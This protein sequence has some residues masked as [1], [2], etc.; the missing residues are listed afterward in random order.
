MTTSLWFWQ[1]DVEL[2]AFEGYDGEPV[3][4][5]WQHSGGYVHK[6]ELRP[7]DHVFFDAD[8][9]VTELMRPRQEKLAAVAR[10]EQQRR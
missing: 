5:R 10:L 9:W 6:E 1:D 8:G 4:L 7:G 3:V 2:T